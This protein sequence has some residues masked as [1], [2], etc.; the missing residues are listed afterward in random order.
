M[1]IQQHARRTQ[2]G[3]LLSDM[4]MRVPHADKGVVVSSDG[5]LLAMSPGLDRA[6]GDRLSAVASSLMGIA[7]GASGPLRGGPVDEVVVQMRNA[8][9]LVTRISEEAS[10]GIVASPRCNMADLAYEMEVFAG[11]TAPLVAKALHPE[12]Q[13]QLPQ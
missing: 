3:T 7:T 11:Q 4:V 5:M 8:I 1:S 13:A 12:L 6:S 10:L 2:L 9:C